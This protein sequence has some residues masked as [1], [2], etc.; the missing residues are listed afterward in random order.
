MFRPKIYI[1]NDA[2]SIS[3]LLYTVDV[4]I[5]RIVFNLLNNELL[6]SYFVIQR[7]IARI[8]S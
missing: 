1:C 4:E 8:K 5:S 3:V 7:L 6:I 2:S